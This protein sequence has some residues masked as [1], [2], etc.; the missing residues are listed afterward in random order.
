MLKYH[1]SDGVLGFP[2]LFLDLITPTSGGIKLGL[3]QRVFL[4][5]LI[6]FPN[7]YAVFPRGY[8]KTFLEVLGLILT[9]VLYP[10]VE[11]SLTAQTR[12]SASSLLEDKV[13]EIFKYYPLLAD[14]CEYKSFTKDKAVLIFKN[15]SR[16]TNL[17]NHQSSKG[18]RRHRNIILRM[19]SNRHRTQL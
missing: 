5:C 9:A 14:C 15:G 11:L 3:D 8:G 1:E 2:D 10:G 17:A 19:S 6:R 16:I 7:V 12:E 13:I 18:K 4:R